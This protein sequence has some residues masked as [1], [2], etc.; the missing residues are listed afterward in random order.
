MSV[1]FSI[2]APASQQ[3]KQNQSSLIYQSTHMQ[4]GSDGSQSPRSQWQ[5]LLRPP[6]ER[7]W[8]KGPQ[9][10][11]IRL[12]FTFSLLQSQQN[13]GKINLDYSGISLH[14]FT[15]SNNY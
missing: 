11:T 12:P 13:T 9:A 3:E 10:N 7:E 4:K 2:R 6:R 14:V 15:I 1:Q 5:I 8:A